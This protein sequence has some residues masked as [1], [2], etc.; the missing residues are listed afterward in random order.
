ME[1]A[2]LASTS[3]ES[4]PPDIV[5]GPTKETQAEAKVVKEVLAVAVKKEDALDYILKKHEF[6][7]AI[8]IAA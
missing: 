5:I 1:W 2:N 4:W 8:R 3:A 6:W 7:K